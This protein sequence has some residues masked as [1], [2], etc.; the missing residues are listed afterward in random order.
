MGGGGV[1]TLPRSGG[2]GCFGG[3]LLLCHPSCGS[4]R[5]LLGLLKSLSNAL[6]L[7]AASSAAS[8]H[9]RDQAE[10]RRYPRQRHLAEE[11]AVS[12]WAAADQHWRKALLAHSRDQAE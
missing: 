3:D 2:E 6:H 1:Y 7:C 11:A 4:P 9:F 10:Q 8:A 12:V 5:P